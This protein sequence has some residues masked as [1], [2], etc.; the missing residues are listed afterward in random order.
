MYEDA[1]EE[2]VGGDVLVV[3]WA[4]GCTP[5]E[6]NLSRAKCISCPFCFFEASNRVDQHLSV[7]KRIDAN[8]LSIR[9]EVNT[10]SGNTLAFVKEET[11]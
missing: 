10:T 8:I 6:R 7:N 3:C 11:C 1:E 2:E 5:R 4:Y 9:Q